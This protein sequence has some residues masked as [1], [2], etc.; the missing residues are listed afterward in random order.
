MHKIK[1]IKIVGFRRLH[2]VE[3]EMHPLMVMI[4]AN[5]VGKSSVLDA[6]ALLSASAS[7]MLNKSLSELGG[8]A[9][10]C[11]HGL[12][13]KLIF[14][15]EMDCPGYEP[16]HYQLEIEA[17]GQGYAIAFDSEVGPLFRQ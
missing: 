5:G 17:K 14:E 7:G 3:I 6:V 12:S 1:K 11:T 13:E 16:L 15:V 4:G 8:V 2:N 10:I 9:D